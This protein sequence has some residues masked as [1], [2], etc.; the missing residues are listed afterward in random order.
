MQRRAFL[1][2]TI[3]ALVA[4]IFNADASTQCG[5]YIRTRQF[6]DARRCETIFDP[7]DLLEAYRSQQ[8]TQ[9]CWA[10]CVSMLF[11][12]HGYTVSQASIVRSVYGSLVDLPSFDGA[13]I[14]RMVNRFWTD[15]STGQEFE[16][17]VLGLLDLISTGSNSVSINNKDIIDALHNN[18]PLILA[19]GTHAMLAVGAVYDE[20]ETSSNPI[21]HRVTVLDPWPPGLPPYTGGIRHL[22]GAQITLPPRGE[23]T[24]LARVKVS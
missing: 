12:F 21:V 1:G 3:S 22:T 15:E 20:V 17:K 8:A 2:G 24:Y 11:R 13:T 9:W 7:P 5:Q 19:S 16:A 10:A 4:P 23:L 18:E 6:G 14:S